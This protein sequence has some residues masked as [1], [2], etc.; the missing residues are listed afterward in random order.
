MDIKTIHLEERPYL[1]IEASAPMDPTKVG[2]AMGAAYGRLSGF[3]AQHGIAPTGQ[4]I[5]V[6][7]GYDPNTMTFRAGMP[8]SADDAG[9]AEG[10][11]KADVLPSGEVFHFTHVGPYAKL[12]DTYQAVEDQVKATGKGLGTPT[13]EVYVDDPAETPEEKLRTDIY[14]VPGEPW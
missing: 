2:E 6:Y 9:K 7:Y 1:Y 14:S 5:S 10:D 13:W 8:V 4:P 3:L 12:R 11:I